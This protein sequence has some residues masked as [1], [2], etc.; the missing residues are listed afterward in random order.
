MSQ[1]T[2]LDL[3]L[4]DV[5]REVQKFLSIEDLFCV[6]CLSSSFRDYVDTEFRSLKAI[7]LPNQNKDVRIALQILIDICG[8]LEELNLSENDWLSDD[9]IMPLLKIN[10]KTLK[11]VKLNRCNSLS[12]VAIPPLLVDCKNLK[13]LELRNCD[14]LTGKHCL[15]IV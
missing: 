11:S 13:K 1:V 10:S 9:L 7:R 15:E 14:W 4:S 6:R 5:F 3:L 8:H 12:P 2:L